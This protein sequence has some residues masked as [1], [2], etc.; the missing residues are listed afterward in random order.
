MAFTNS[1]GNKKGP[2]IAIIVVAVILLL[3]IATVTLTLVKSGS[4]T[5]LKGVTVG[6]VDLSGCTIDEAEEKLLDRISVIKDEKIIITAGD[7][8]LEAT[9]SQFGADYDC[10]LSAEN[11]YNYGHD[12]FFSS[13][14]PAIK[15]LFGIETEHELSVHINNRIFDETMASFTSYDKSVQASYEFTEDAIIV[16]NGK[17]ARTINPVT[18]RE[19]LAD[20][21]KNLDFSSVTFV[22]ENIDPIPLDIDLIID[23]YSKEAVSASYYRDADGNIKITDG[24]D[25][26]TVNAKLA[27]ELIEKH[28]KPGETFEIPATIELAKYTRDELEEALFRDV[29]SSYTTSYSSSGAN[30]SHN[31]ALAAS[32]CNGKIL[33]PGEVFSYNDTLGRRTAAAGYK[34]AGAYLN[35]ETVQE[36]GGGICQVSS[37]LYVSVLKANLKIEERLCHMF[38]VAYVPIGLDATVDY[39]TVDFKFSND[40]DFP[41]KIVAYTTDSKQVICEIVGTK[42]ENFEVSFETT[43]ISAVPYTTDTIED[44]TLPLG[45]EK[46]DEKGSNG[47]KCTVYRIVSVDGEVK[48]RTLE[49]TSYYMAHKEVKRVGTNAELAASTEVTDPN[50]PVTESPETSAPVTET[51]VVPETSTPVTET[52]AVPETSTPVTETPAVPET[53]TPVTETPAVPETTA[54]VTE[55]PAVS[56]L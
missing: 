39:G 3:I 4:D 1:S 19:T 54:P 17:S 45:E 53:S 46:I 56:E 5:I 38:R 47:S 51:P 22:I 30:R 28:T 33:L 8:V 44:P 7:D 23:K 34:M 11:A 32:S 42:T 12:G 29:L 16:T 40:T 50:A 25:K 35:G 20:A 15:S 2:I 31:V 52:P 14:M 49:S 55:A 27:K 36:Y 13:I 37:T 6:G 24:N 10:R 9:Y 26:V 41:V 18:A 48:S 43:G 21:M